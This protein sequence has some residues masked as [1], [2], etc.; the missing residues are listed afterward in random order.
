MNTQF[1]AL[2]RTAATRSTY[3]V[4]GANLAKRLSAQ[5]G[6]EDPSELLA[7]FLSSSVNYSQRTF[8]L[9]KASLLQHFTDS[10]VAPSVLRLLKLAS[11]KDL[12]K[13]SVHTSGLKA[14][15]VQPEDQVLLL[16]M[17][18]T[19]RS[20]TAGL[21]ADYFQAGLIAGPRPVEWI[22]ATLE[23]LDRGLPIDAPASATHR[24]SFV[25]AKRDEFQIR[26]NGATRS[27]YLTLGAADAAAIIRVIADARA[28]AKDW[29]MHYDRL[30]GVLRYAAKTLWP[31]RKKV[32]CFYT[33]RHQS[34]AN[35]KASGKK[36]NEVAAIYGHASDNTAT[37][38]Y[39]RASQGDKNMYKA[40][41]T[42][43]S[44]AQVR[45]QKVTARLLGRSKIPKQMVRKKGQDT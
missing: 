38:H 42:A 36:P 16:A 11:S 17:L 19:R 32:P 15:S 4:K 33:T 39:A 44:L 13:R 22:G 28:N 31:K 8:R 41:P 24:I 37:Q 18:R 12:P 34:Q 1:P 30:R 43:L 23:V 29:D 40:A 35:A 7:R 20:K 10:G 9:Y 5:V 27:V 3:E 2:G 45:N 26:G 25:N 14:K 6:T 21:A